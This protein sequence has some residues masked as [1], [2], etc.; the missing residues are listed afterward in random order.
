MAGGNTSAAKISIAERRAMAVSLRKQGGSF[1][2]IAEQM[3]KQEGISDKYTEIQ[4]YRDVSAELTRIREQSAED[5]LDV[6]Q[7]E[8]MRLDDIISFLWQRVKKGDLFCIDRVFRAMEIRARYLGLFPSTN[9]LLSVQ[10]NSLNVNQNVVVYLP[11][12]GR[13]DVSAIANPILENQPVKV[14]AGPTVTNAGNGNDRNTP[15]T[16]AA[17]SVPK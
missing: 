16:G 14:L 8:L 15:P 9:P 7:L 1:R 4:A 6:L 17:N 3:R 5:A 2:A 13:G 12:N 10:N 11:D